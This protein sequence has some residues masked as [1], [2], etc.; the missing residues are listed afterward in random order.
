MRTAGFKTQQEHGNKIYASGSPAK[1]HSQSLTFFNLF[2]C[3]SCA[4][5][6]SFY[7]LVLAM[8][9]SNFKRMYADFIKTNNSELAHT[10][11]VFQ[12]PKRQSQFLFAL[13]LSLWNP[14]V[15]DLVLF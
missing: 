4:T 14:L 5:C 7:F 2:I 10:E 12:I 13:E 11:S 8:Q 9:K 15:Q 3:F 1:M 6:Q